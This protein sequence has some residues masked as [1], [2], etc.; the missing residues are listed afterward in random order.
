MKLTGKLLL[1][2]IIAVTFFCAGARAQAAAQAA[3]RSITD[4]AG[5]TVR[6]PD[7]ITRVV[8]TSPVG[9]ILLYT[10]C[11][12]MLAGWNH[13]LRSG[14]REFIPEPYRS[15]PNLGGWYAKNTGSLEELVRL[16]PDVL[17]GA[18][19][20]GPAEIEQADRI[21]QQI[22]IPVI[23]LDGSLE[24]LEKAY[25][26]LGELTGERQRAGILAAYCRE[27]LAAVD[28]ALAG[29]PAEGSTRIYYAEGAAGLETEP[30]GSDHTGLLSR[31]G[32]SNVAQVPAR[33]G[34]GMTPVS[35]EQVIAWNPEALLVW[36]RGQGGAYDHIMSD[37]L[38]AKLL[39]VKNRRVY[40]IPAAPF[41]WFDRPPAVNRVIGLLW[42]TRLLH[43]DRFACDIA[44]EAQRFCRLFYH[45][46]LS[47]D[48][49]RGLLERSGGA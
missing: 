49:I 32:G 21:Q 44:A 20:L 39:A 30:G 26:F 11:P 19:K 9:T 22:N 10:L 40:E 4:H 28:T 41:N 33:E 45:I 3:G 17:I 2:C 13:A 27:K 12:D 25:L 36:N 5:R 24:G 7:R 29:L 35:M 1:R 15:L 42:L 8:G 23:M 14:E 47:D 38:W 46:D 37:P 6:V 43:P 48:Q 16:R 31:V 34:I 18:G